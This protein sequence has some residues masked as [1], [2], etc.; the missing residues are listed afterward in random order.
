MYFCRE[1][2]PVYESLG[3]KQLSRDHE[4]SRLVA[5]RSIIAGWSSNRRSTRR[6]AFM[7]QNFHEISLSRAAEDARIPLVGSVTSFSRKEVG[8]EL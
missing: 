8:V 7:N 4:Q 2:R 6:I 5:N 3:G 1:S